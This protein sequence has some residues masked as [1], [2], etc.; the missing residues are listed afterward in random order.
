MAIH[1]RTRLTGLLE[2]TYRL[3]EKQMKEIVSLTTKNV[4]AIGPYNLAV[5][6][7]GFLFTSGMIGIDPETNELKPCVE[8]QAEQIFIN[9]KNI[10][11]IVI[12]LSKMLLKL[13]CF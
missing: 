7:N 13:L 9:L 11:R 1:D 4:M 3:E 12:S 10:L 6:A 5:K 2:F 8:S